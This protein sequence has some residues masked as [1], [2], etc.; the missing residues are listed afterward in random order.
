MILIHSPILLH[1]QTPN[2][3]T[4]FQMLVIFLLIHEQQHSLLWILIPLRKHLIKPQKRD[5]QISRERK[6][7]LQYLLLTQNRWPPSNHNSK[8]SVGHGYTKKISFNLT[9]ILISVLQ[10]DIRAEIEQL[11]LEV[12]NTTI[13]YNQAC[14]DLVHAQNRVWAQLLHHL[15]IWSFV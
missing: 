7:S 1:L 14:Q 6:N 4:A 11:R 3:R 5:S 10:S 8:Y 13:M 15:N 9:G 2:I 12:E